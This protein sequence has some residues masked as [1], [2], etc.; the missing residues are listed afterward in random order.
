M[1]E[2][3]SDVFEVDGMI[4]CGTPGCRNT[5][6][7]V[8]PFAREIEKHGLPVHLMYSDAFDDRVES[9]EATAGRLDEFFKVRGLL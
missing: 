9:W 8:K 5:W 1:S 6:G 3:A 4:Y 2:R 7:M